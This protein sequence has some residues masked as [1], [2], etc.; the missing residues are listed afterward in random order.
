[1]PDLAPPDKQVAR[2]YKCPYP[3]CGR[4]F[5]RLEH[6]TRH[7][8][9]H[10]G[11]K[12]FLCTFPGCEKRFSRSDELTRHSRIHNNDNQS[13]TASKKSGVKSRLEF[14]SIG[15]QAH[16]PFPG[17]SNSASMR[18]KKK[19][20]S[21]ANSDD[22]GE[23][24]A[25]P[26]VLGSYDMP[27]PRRT[28]PAQHPQPSAFNALSTVAVDELHALER[29]EAARRAEYE[30]RRAEAL[31]R[32]ESENRFQLEAPNPYFRHRLTKS[33][34]TS[35]T[36]T[37]ALRPGL[38]LALTPEEQQYYGLSNERDGH[39]VY[40]DK[41]SQRRLS[42]PWHQQPPPSSHRSNLVQSR[43]SGHLVDQMRP[44]GASY[45]AH[46]YAAWSHPYHPQ[47]P[48]AHYRHLAG[49]NTHEDSP[50]PISSDSE[51]AANNSRSPSQRLFQINPPSSL[52]HSRPH[53][54]DHSP[55]HYSSA[56]RTTSADVAYTPSTSPFL[57]PLRTL[58]IHS[59]NPSR[60]PSPVLLPP[61]TIEGRDRERDM[62]ADDSRS[63]GPSVAGSPTNSSILMPQHRGPM[64]KQSQ[65]SRR[66]DS[67]GYAMPPLP[68]HYHQHHPYLASSSGVPT[69][70]LSSGP[71]SNGSS[72][73][74]L[75]Q[76]TPL[77]PPPLLP[78]GAGLAV[79]NISSVSATSSRA[80]SPVSW[81]SSLA[82]GH[83]TATANVFQGGKREQSHSNLAHSVRMAFGM[84][85]IVPSPPRSHAHAHSHSR[86]E[87]GLLLGGGASHP[88]S[89]VTTPMHPHS[90]SSLSSSLWDLRSMPG[91]RSGSPPITLPPLKVPKGLNGDEESDDG[92]DEDEDRVKVKKEVL[93][94]VDMLMDG[95]EGPSSSKRSGGKARKAERERV[96]LPGFSQ[97]E[98]A[99]RGLPLTS[100]MT[101]TP[102]AQKMSIDFVRS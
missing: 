42:G 76:H 98:A 86:T 55:P 29:Q 23:S 35:P 65:S 81:T 80:P 101:S 79:S 59:T 17:G 7:I 37:P 52:H 18:A 10:T 57:G 11:E 75:G 3:L 100:T 38:A 54:S 61:P 15:E 9:T 13:S 8:R 6:Q 58:N 83:M 72:P 31:R 71:S 95:V 5:S 73:G 21:R 49:A 41:K 27:H 4:A 36:A 1:M 85:P 82:A 32:V 34:T 102:A 51:T 69:P 50:S 33:A 91:S 93:D 28:Q 84:T 26:T 99:A 92:V 74:S 24:Y 70:Q 56:M 20:R 48:H 14:T 77:G 90:H 68:H 66:T 87:S 97:F 30:A 39:P 60:A 88:V 96:E 40:D 53:S 25:R 94:D 47:P 64:M 12:P 19:A 78:P 45:G 46:H 44:A 2:P 89:G 67:L 63:R 16:P 22:E 43:S 62:A